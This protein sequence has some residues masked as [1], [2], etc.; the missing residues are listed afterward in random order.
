MAIGAPGFSVQRGA[1]YVVLGSHI[2]TIGHTEE[3]IENVSDLILSGE[4]PNNRFGFSMTSLDFNLDGYQVW[5]KFS[6]YF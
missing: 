3:I 1:V 6:D 5:E 2:P 4:N